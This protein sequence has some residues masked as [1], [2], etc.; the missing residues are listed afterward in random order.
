MTPQKIS[1]VL[2]TLFATSANGVETGS[3]VLRL[4]VRDSATGL[5]VPT[6]TLET[7]SGTGVSRKSEQGAGLAKF[8]LA[9]GLIPVK[10]TAPGYRPLST[11]IEVFANATGLPVTIWLDPEDTPVRL[12]SVRFPLIE[13]TR[14]T[15]YVVDE[16][17]RP[18]GNV[19]VRSGSQHTRSNLDGYFELRFPTDLTPL[20]IPSLRDL[21]FELDGY[22]THLLSNLPIAGGEVE[23]TVEMGKG[24]GSEFEDQ[25]PKVLRSA[26][27]QENAQLAINGENQNSSAPSGIGAPSPLVPPSSIRVGYNCSCTNCSTVQV[28]SLETYV[29]RGLK[30]EWISSWSQHSLRA[31]AIAYRSYGAYYV[32]HPMRSNYDIC[33]TACCQVNTSGTVAS[34]DNAVAHTAG[35]LLQRGGQVFRAEYS[36][37]NNNS[38][39]GARTCSNRSCRCGNGNAGSPGANWP[40]VAEP[41]DASATCSGHG[42]GMCQ[43][44]TQRVSLQGQLWNWIED[45]Y[46]NNN[47]LPSGLRSAR[48][49]SP[50]D[51]SDFYADP[52]AISAGD[53][54]TLWYSVANYSE[55]YHEQ[56]IMAASLYSAASGYVSDSSNDTRISAPPGYSDQYRWFTTPPGLP[57][58]SY[59]LVVAL[60][61]DVNEDGAIT[62]VDLPLV[63]YSWPG[64]ITIN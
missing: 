22:K 15:G 29:R 11:A 40:C 19:N 32:Y 61:I 44:G 58:G 43:W 37:E 33:N 4:K 23:I 55:L 63:T 34:T 21:T 5:A 7:G 31:G 30:A 35:I 14:V 10:L 20:D 60:W 1:V 27:E 41:W 48:M 42:R 18:L 62:S 59:D 39:C 46:Y 52:L 51:I 16:D 6:F 47:G 12:R 54:L 24:S 8:S 2:F 57:S 38:N 17:G 49:T 64:A 13:G 25:T 3:G 36:A 53:T 45:H 9:P 56:V 26:S 50:L 28:M